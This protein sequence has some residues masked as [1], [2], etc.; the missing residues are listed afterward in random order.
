MQELCVGYRTSLP[1]G[2]IGW[3]LAG[4]PGLFE[5][6]LE[7]AKELEKQGLWESLA[8]KKVPAMSNVETSGYVLVMR[9]N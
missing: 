1:G 4:C 9:R 2:I 7:K 6:Y 3:T 8:V 5:D